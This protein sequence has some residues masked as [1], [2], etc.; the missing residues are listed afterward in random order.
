[1][2]AAGVIAGV[3]RQN[4]L[5]QKPVQEN[6]G[7][8]NHWKSA[9]RSDGLRIE[10][11]STWM[12]PSSSGTTASTAATT[13]KS[14]VSMMI[15]S[16]SSLRLMRPTLTPSAATLVH[17][18]ETPNRSY[19][20]GVPGNEKSVQILSLKQNSNVTN[21]FKKSVPVTGY[22][23]IWNTLKTSAWVD[24]NWELLWWWLNQWRVIQSVK[25]HCLE[26]TRIWNTFYCEHCE[27]FLF[28]S[29]IKDPMDFVWINHVLF[30]R[31]LFVWTMFLKGNK[32]A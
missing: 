20:W 15:T 5:Y 2:M 6:I 32:R 9:L 31:T 21:S 4:C 13:A 14:F 10:C 28:L 26:T 8:T 11:Q 3:V 19:L 12:Y 7:N 18:H 30:T 1:M 17:L 25:C 22:L 24:G 27:V 16:V 29:P 23:I